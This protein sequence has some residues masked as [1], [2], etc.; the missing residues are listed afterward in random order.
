MNITAQAMIGELVAKDYRTATVFKKHKID[1]CCNG[2]RSIAEAC[3]KKKIDSQT[4]LTQLQEAV[5]S[6]NSERI[7]FQTWPADLLIDYIEKKHHRYVE[8]RIPI[9]KEFLQKVATVHGHHRTELLEVRAEFDAASA[10]LAAHMKKEEIILFPYIKKMLQAKS[11]NKAPQLPPFGS[12]ENPIKMMHQ[13]HDT[14]GERFR[15]IEQLTNDYQ[16]PEEACNTYRVSYAMLKEF[17]DDL[18]QHIHLENNILFPKAIA[19]EAE[20][21]GC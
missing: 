10:A 15:K 18:H 13:E 8:E 7:D 14:E 12:V 2:G 6:G 1:F 4:L 5:Q 21:T 17:Q 3:E 16:P 9:L 19:L 20:L 11:A